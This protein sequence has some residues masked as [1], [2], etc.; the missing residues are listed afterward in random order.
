[1]A[2]GAAGSALNRARG[3]AGALA[4][5]GTTNEEAFLLQRLL[6]EALDSPHLD[7]R[8]AGGPPRELAAAL[9]APALAATMLDVE[10]AHAVLV[11]DCEPV[12][13]MPIL[14]LRIRKGVRRVSGPRAAQAARAL[15]N[16]AERL[17]LAEHEGAGLLEAPAHANGR[18]LREAGVL[19]DAAPGWTEPAAAGRSAAEIAAGLADGE[20][21]TL[22]LLHVDPL[23]AQPDRG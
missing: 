16:V 1:R 14:D 18:G 8:P 4:G 12:D 21:T 2:L 10:H 3:R 17:R 9:G 19:P 15:L 13:D 5:D 20:L 23:R 7:S 11:L 22:Y 6:R